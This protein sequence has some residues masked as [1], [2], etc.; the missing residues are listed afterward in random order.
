M[1]CELGTPQGRATVLGLCSHRALEWAP[2][3]TGWA[4]V[5]LPFI[6]QAVSGFQNH[7]PQSKATPREPN[8]WE[9]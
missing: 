7:H 2:C 3:G 9:F 4:A 5:T 6:L 1:R 8:S